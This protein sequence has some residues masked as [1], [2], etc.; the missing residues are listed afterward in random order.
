MIDLTPL[1]VRKKKGDFRRALR[2][3]EPDPVDGFLDLAAD[4][5]EELVRENAMLRE[6]NMQLA[7]QLSSYRSRENAMNEALVTAQ[8]LRE[9]VRAQASREAEL[10][11]REARAEAERIVAGARQSAA[12]V[13]ESMRRIQGQRARFLRSFRALVERQLAEVEMEEERVREAAHTEGREVAPTESDLPR[14]A[15]EPRVAARPSRGEGVD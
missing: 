6:R 5:L 12:A 15:G 1:D 7:E 13:A 10:V 4:R 14:P 8:Q 9:E 2:G 11:L 3:Y